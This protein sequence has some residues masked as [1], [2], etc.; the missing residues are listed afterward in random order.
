[1]IPSLATWRE[2]GVIKSVG[3]VRASPLESNSTWEKSLIVIVI[4]I[5]IKLKLLSRS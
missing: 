2:Y 5:V 1:V 3:S 4:V